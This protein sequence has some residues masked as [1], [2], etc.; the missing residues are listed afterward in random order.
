ME[1]MKVF[2]EKYGYDNFH[3]F[4]DD[5]LFDIDRAEELAKAIK[6]LGRNWK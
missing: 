4:D 2:N 3:F 1:E 5:F 6:S